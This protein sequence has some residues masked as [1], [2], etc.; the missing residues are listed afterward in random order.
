M[1]IRSLKSLRLPLVFV[2]AVASA[3]L[4]SAATTRSLPSDAA[5]SQAVSGPVKL[6]ACYKRV[7][8]G[9]VCT[10]VRVPCEQKSPPATTSV[11]G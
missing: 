11:R 5:R 7:C 10:N 1:M 8:V 6:A 3:G 9:S 4:S 2:G